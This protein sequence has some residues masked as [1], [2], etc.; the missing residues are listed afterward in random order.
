M[1]KRKKQQAL[2]LGKGTVVS[3]SRCF[4]S[5]L[6]DKIVVTKISREEY[7]SY[8]SS[9]LGLARRIKER[10]PL[11]KLTLLPTTT[12]VLA[13]IKGDLITADLLEKYGESYAIKQGMTFPIFAVI[14]INYQEEGIKVFDSC[15]RINKE[16]IDNRYLH[17]NGD[18]ELCTHKPVDIT[19]EN[20]V[21]D[22]LQSAWHLYTEYKKYERTGRFDLDC[23]EHGGNPNER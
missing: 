2:S 20:A 3:N 14:P 5:G 8:Y 19:P 17:M 12:W 9:L 1:K 10:F 22:V 11:L 7:N 23:Y 15:N 21:I 6:L 16:K 13:Y 18:N 4:D